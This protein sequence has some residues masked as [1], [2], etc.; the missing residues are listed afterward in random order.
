MANITGG[1]ITGI[2]V[3]AGGSGYTSAQ[4]NITDSTGTGAIAVATVANGVITGITVTAGG[5]GYTSGTTV[6]HLSKRNRGLHLWSL[7]RRKQQIRTGIGFYQ[8][9]R[10]CECRVFGRMENLASNSLNGMKT[11]I[12]TWYSLGSYVLRDVSGLQMTLVST[13][14]GFYMPAPVVIC[15]QITPV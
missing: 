11:Q 8:Q 1:V 13:L 12:N 7:H 4:V 9:L 10:R 15:W 6:I 14:M 2:T 3:T 5:S